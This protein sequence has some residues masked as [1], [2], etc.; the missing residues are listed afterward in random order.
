MVFIR[1]PQVR[2]TAIK[3]D[4]MK[5][6]F[7]LEA[8]GAAIDTGKVADVDPNLGANVTSRTRVPDLVANL[9]LDRDWGHFQAAAI[10]REIAFETTGTPGNEPS[11]EE[12]GYGLNL[13]GS[14]KTIGNDR[15][16]GQLVVGQGIAS[17]MNDGGVDLAPGS[18]L[19]AETVQT[20]GWFAYYDHY[21]NDLWSS[22]I[23]YSE[24]RQDNTG[25]QTADAFKKGSYASVNLLYYPVKNVMAGAELLWG[26]RENNNGASGDDTRIQF[27]AKYKF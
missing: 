7:S 24:H 17:Y 19:R 26:E 23:G 5:V 25:G 11:G 1:N 8:P 6:A 4:G 12:T 2:Y 9:R 22:S 18:N 21:W 16:V 20:I 3:R 13:S 27:S 15:V 14:F 10:L